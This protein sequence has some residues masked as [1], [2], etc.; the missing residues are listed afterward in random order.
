[1]FTPL[2]IGVC[3]ASEREHQFTVLLLFYHIVNDRLLSTPC[4]LTQCHRVFLTLQLVVDVKAA[5]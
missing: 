2:S 1:M 5:T 3:A 4:I